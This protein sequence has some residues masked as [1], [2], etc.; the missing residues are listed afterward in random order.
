VGVLLWEA[1]KAV[2]QALGGVWPGT[3]VDLP[4]RPDDRAM[5]HVWE[6]VGVLFA[7][8]RRGGEDLLGTILLQAALYTWRI[9]LVGFVVGSVFG[10]LVA[11]LLV[12][13]RL[14]ERALLRTSSP[15]RPSRSWRSRRSSSSGRAGP[16]SRPG[17]RSR[18]S[19]RTSASTR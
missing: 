13:S 16:G 6:I 15:A 1:Y 4:V 18:S 2:G 3:E 17:S 12:R 10:L 9:A 14:A 11:V 7:P 5:P 8:A 19:R